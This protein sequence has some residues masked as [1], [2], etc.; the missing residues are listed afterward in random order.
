MGSTIEQDPELVE[1]FGRAIVRAQVFA[2]N[3]ANRAKVLAHL[4]AGMPQESEDPEFAEALFEAV[5]AKT[6]PLDP[7]KGWG[8]QDPAHWQRWH[9]SVVETGA[10]EQPLPDLEA[11]YTNEFVPAWN[12]GI[13]K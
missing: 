4:K 7:S 12:E 2:I 13:P 6:I 1:A 10:L 8:Y 9:D 11:A 3:E 5:L